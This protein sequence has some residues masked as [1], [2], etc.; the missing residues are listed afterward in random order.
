MKLDMI[1]T[2][3]PV[4]W[5]YLQGTM[6]QLSFGEA[7]I[8]LVISVS[9]HWVPGW[10]LMVNYCHPFAHP[11]GIRQLGDP[12]SPYLVY[13]MGKDYHVCWS[14]MM[15]DGLIGAFGSILVHL[16]FLTY[17]LLMI[18]WCI[19]KPMVGVPQGWMISWR[20]IVLALAKVQTSRR[21]RF[22]LVQLWG[23]GVKAA[24]NTQCIQKWSYSKALIIK[25]M[26]MQT[27]LK[28]DFKFKRYNIFKCG[29]QN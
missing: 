2:Y 9:P 10:R 12:I 8:S 4:E 26:N 3:D 14:S 17:Y 28:P 7:W 13:Y 21:A 23:R 5:V 16:G 6:Q 19:R 27:K 25:N 20:I 24:L 18:V 15:V 11:R 1:K 29:S 22:S